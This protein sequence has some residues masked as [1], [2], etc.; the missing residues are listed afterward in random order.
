[1][2]QR[3]LEYR[4]TD[5]HRYRL[6]RLRGIRED[7]WVRFPGPEC[8]FGL[9]H[10]RGTLGVTRDGRERSTEGGGSQS[11]EAHT[12]WGSG[13][14]ERPFGTRRLPPI[15]VNTGEKAPSVTTV[16][17]FSWLIRTRKKIHTK[18]ASE[19]ST[20]TVSTQEPQHFSLRS[21]G[22]GIFS[23]SLFLARVSKLALAAPIISTQWHCTIAPYPKKFP[24]K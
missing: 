20:P 22:G 5:A 13:F 11:H 18:I 2:Y 8:S 6:V 23:E 12:K 21:S 17:S 14:A 16:Y 7:G 9:G 15:S 24:N 10:P 1:M 4:G 3:L 19:I